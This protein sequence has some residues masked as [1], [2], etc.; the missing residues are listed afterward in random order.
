MKTIQE[1]T[2]DKLNIA[3]G[4][5]Q[6]ALINTDKIGLRSDIIELEMSLKIIIDDLR[7]GKIDAL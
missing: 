6:R 2:A 1:I 7:K 5:I 3:L 4:I